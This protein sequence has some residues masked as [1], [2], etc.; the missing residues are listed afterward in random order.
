MELYLLFFVMLK[1]GLSPYKK[2][3]DSE[4]GAEHNIWTQETGNNGGAEKVA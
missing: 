2:S 3:T 1:P 4:W